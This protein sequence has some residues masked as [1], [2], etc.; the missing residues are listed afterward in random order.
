MKRTPVPGTG[1][2]HRAVS[3]RASAASRGICTS[4]LILQ[5]QERGFSRMHRTTP[6]LLRVGEEMAPP[7]HQRCEVVD[8]DDECACASNSTLRKA[9][10]AS[11]GASG[12]IRVPAVEESKRKCRSPDSLRSLGM[13][14]VLG[15][16]DR[17]DQPAQ[18]LRR[19]PRRQE[20]R[21]RAI[22]SVVAGRGDP[23]SRRDGGAAAGRGTVALS[24]GR[25]F[26]EP[27]GAPA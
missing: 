23:E 24:V 6:D 13:T 2:W 11:S 22:E 16:G 25:R 17:G 5:R 3:S 8:G 20:L 7:R 12:K 26:G 14:A 19:L 21:V 4:P 1:A 9:D 27:T 18:Q 10:P 15:A